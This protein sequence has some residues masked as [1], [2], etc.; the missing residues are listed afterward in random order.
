MIDLL[1]MT[2]Y[3]ASKTNRLDLAHHPQSL[4]NILATGLSLLNRLVH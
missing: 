4:I 3:M 2:K 1:Q